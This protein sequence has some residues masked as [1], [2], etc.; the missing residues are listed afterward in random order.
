MSSRSMAIISAAL[1]RVLELAENRGGCPAAVTSDVH[2]AS[3][4]DIPTFVERGLP[5]LS[6][7]E[8]GGIK[9]AVARA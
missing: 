7:S 6:F 2:L 1:D 4:P 8:W 5:A 9:R 3:A